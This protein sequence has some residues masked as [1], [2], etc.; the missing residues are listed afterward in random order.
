MLGRPGRRDRKRL[1][2]HGIR[3]PATVLEI[4]ERGMAITHGSEAIVSNTELVLKC[5]L[6][7]EPPGQ[8]VFDVETKLRFPQLAVPSAGSTIAVIYDP[9]DPGT[10]MLDDSP[11]AAMSAAMSHLRPDQIASIEAAHEMATAGA[12]PEAIRARV[13]EIRAAAG[14]PPAQVLGGEPAAAPDPVAQLT[15]LAAL[16][17]RGVLTEEEFAVAKARVLGGG[18]GV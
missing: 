9:E 1:E 13:D 2:E 6:R 4:A 15:Q 10:L 11:A 12:S 16:R 18:S 7:V 3:A 17:D 5:T 14:Q 8:P